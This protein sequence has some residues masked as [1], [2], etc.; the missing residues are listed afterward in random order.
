LRKKKDIYTPRQSDAKFLAKD[1]EQGKAE[2]QGAD[3]RGPPRL[4]ESQ[5]RFEIL[6]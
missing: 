2:W 1:V 6:S 4:R 5:V 3:Q